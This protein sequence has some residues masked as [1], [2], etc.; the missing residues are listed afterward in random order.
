MRK[1]TTYALAGT[2]LAVMAWGTYWLASD[3]GQDGSAISAP[4]PPTVVVEAAR[5]RVDALQPTITTIGTLRSEESIVLRPELAGRVTTIGFKEGQPVEAG[6][7]LVALD[8]SI[9][10]AELAQAEASLTLSRTNHERAQ[11]LVGRGAVSERS[12]DEALAKLRMDEASV[13]LARARLEKTRIQA[14]HDGVMG[15]RDV[16]VGDYV[17]PGDR[18]VALDVVNPIKLAFRIPEVYLADVSPGQQVSFELDAL[19]GRQFNAEIYAIDPQVDI[20]GR[21]LAVLARAGNPDR[22]LR[23]GL[24]AR[25]SLI[26]PPKPGAVLVPEQAVIP[27]GAEHFLFRVVDGKAAQTPIEIGMRRAGEVEIVHGVSAED[28]V[29]TSGHLKLRDGFAVTIRN[30]LDGAS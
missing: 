4:A 15:L 25:T 2:A 7:L 28:V 19:P 30:P 26:L 14:P 9:Y 21:S 5:V 29:V 24:F 6:Q 12:L 17:Q 22:I 20:N 1:A 23:P 11:E 13:A 16:G 3:D 10:E 18:L 27:S 8:G